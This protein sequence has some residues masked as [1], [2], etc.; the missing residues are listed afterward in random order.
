MRVRLP[1]LLSATALSLA[2]LP[3]GC[4]A[5]AESEN[6]QLR[7]FLVDGPLTGFQEVNLD[8]QEVRI[9]TADGWVTLGTPDRVVNLLSLVGGVAS[10]LVDGATLP[11]GSYGQLRLIL[12][13]RNTLKLADGSVVPL[14]TPSGLQS[15]IKLVTSFQVEPGT[16]K[17]IWIDFDAARSVKVTQTGSGSGKYILRPTVWAVD[18]V[19]TGSISG[20]LTAAAGGPLADVL[21]TAQTLDGSGQPTVVRTVRTAADGRYTLDLLPVGATYFVVSQP[22]SGTTAFEAK[23][24]APFALAAATPTFTY[25]ASF[26]P[27]A[28]TGT[29][30]GSFVTPATTSEH[31]EVDLLQALAGGTFV[32]RTAFPVV[33]PTS[34]TYTLDMVPAGTYTARA[35]R[36]TMAPDGTTTRATTSAPAFTVSSGATTTVNF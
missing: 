32:L 34:E 16:T 29:V 26:A 23:A 9:A 5:S 27:A 28:A 4:S 7:V 30:S 25:A 35:I 3:L 17:D 18:R 22:V 15:G 2:L 19:A 12:G 21:V 36:T 11:A 24:S 6:G 31:D 14:E 13:T 10:T 1:L 20:T 8:I 33:G